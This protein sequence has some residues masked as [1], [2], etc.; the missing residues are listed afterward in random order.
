MPPITRIQGNNHHILGV[1]S[2][3]QRKVEE[4]LEYLRIGFKEKNEAIL[5]VTDELTK[6]EVRN[7]IIKKVEDFFKWIGRPRKR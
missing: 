7:E 3:P 6:D 1:F 2:S 5:L 4:G